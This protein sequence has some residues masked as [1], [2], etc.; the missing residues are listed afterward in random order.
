MKPRI[1]ILVD[2]PG[3]ALDRTADNVIA[4]LQ[5]R[6]RFKKAY[7]HD[8]EAMLSSST[9]DLC[10]MAYWRQLSDAGITATLPR[11]AVTGVRSHFKWDGGTGK[12]PSQKI[13]DALGRF[14]ALHV[15]SRILYDIF[16]YRH[17][18]VFYT[19]HGVDPAVFR[20]RK[21]GPAASPAG[22]LILGWAGSRTNHP[23]KRGIEDYLLPAIKGLKGITIRYAAR[24]DLWR[25]QAEM[26]PFYQE[27][28]AYVCASRT[29]GGPHPLL[30][31]GAC[32][33]PV[34]STRVGLAPEL[35]H[36]GTNGLL[37]ER[38]VA[39]LRAAIIRLR[40]KRDL[41]I[42]MGKTA[43]RII[44]EKWTW[45]IQA[46]NYQPFFDCGLEQADRD[47]CC[48]NC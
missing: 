25:T 10:Y 4:R 5:H 21:K 31:A 20:P 44:C 3:W 22:R 19:P 38:S 35:L 46:K 7:N 32:G 37:V 12:P 1:L 47:T 43:R 17:R 41:R 29:E 30:E 9:F 16:R 23:G 36:T 39:A 15:P 42:E 13:I 40:D 28:D 26:V 2:V 45:D 14:N 48:R 6:Y 34:I 18:A 33:I 24:E 11:P 8:A 27:L